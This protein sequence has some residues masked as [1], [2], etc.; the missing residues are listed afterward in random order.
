KK[1]ILQDG[2]NM[3]I[4]FLLYA[5][6]SYIVS[7]AIIVASMIQI[8]KHLT[9][10]GIALSARTIL[11]QR[12]FFVMQILQNIL[13]LVVLSVPVAIGAYG[14]IAD[15]DLGL[16]TLPLTGFAWLVPSVQASVQLRYVRQASANTPENSKATAMTTLSSR[17]N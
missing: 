1:C 6:I 5:V 17:K 15:A 4:F 3:L 9:S 14:A 10:D 2:K 11:L 16:A 7:Y 13:P 8:N 12:Q